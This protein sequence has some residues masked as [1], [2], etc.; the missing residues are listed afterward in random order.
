[1]SQVF[2]ADSPLI[3]PVAT[4]I[5]VVAFLKDLKRWTVCDFS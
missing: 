5:I 4:H 3:D 1:M 2:M